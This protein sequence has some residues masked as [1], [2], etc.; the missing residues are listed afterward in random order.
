MKIV[1]V[2]QKT[3]HLQRM[4]VR[5]EA[6]CG[7]VISTHNNAENLMKPHAVVAEAFHKINFWDVALSL[8]SGGSWVLWKN[9]FRVSHVVSGK[10]PRNLM[11]LTFTDWQTLHVSYHKTSI[12]FIAFAFYNT[13]FSSREW[14]E[15]LKICKQTVVPHSIEIFWWNKYSLIMQ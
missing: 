14:W 15:G 13:L 6:V 5:C 11:Q 4:C 9:R 8:S 12:N 10:Y 1:H 3:L 7:N 2:L